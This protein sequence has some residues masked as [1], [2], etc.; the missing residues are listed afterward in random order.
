M[1][2]N[3]NNLKEILEDWSLSSNEEMKNISSYLLE[4][5]YSN[6]NS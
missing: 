6:N 3:E 2:L 5:Y 4:N 1:K